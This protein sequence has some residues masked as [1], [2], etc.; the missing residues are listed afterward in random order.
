MAFS[1]NL[2]NS[3]FY[4][5]FI[6]N[7]NLYSFTWQRILSCHDQNLQNGANETSFCNYVKRILL[8]SKI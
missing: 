2:A 6:C 5:H 7:C 8:C 4:C 1:V 3:E